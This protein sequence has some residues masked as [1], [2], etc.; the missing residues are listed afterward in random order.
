MLL[1]ITG[2]NKKNKKTNLH[3]F[4]VQVLAGWPRFTHHHCRDQ[5]RSLVYSRQVPT[6]A[7][8]QQFKI[9]HKIVPSLLYLFFLFQLTG[10]KRTPLE[11]GNKF[12]RPNEEPISRSRSRSE[13]DL[14]CHVKESSCLT[15]A[16]IL[17]PP[18]GHP[19]QW[20]RDALLHVSARLGWF[21]SCAAADRLQG[22]GQLLSA[23]QAR[24]HAAGHPADVHARSQP[25]RLCSHFAL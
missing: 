19:V 13:F 22:A 8:Q 11:S 18:C 7:Q 3:R 16:A 2:K 4:V 15:V 23:H 12:L 9:L 17:T 25:G 20:R 14:L 21:W 5:V 1:M 6:V 10:A 24:A